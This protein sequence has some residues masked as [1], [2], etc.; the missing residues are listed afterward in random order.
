MT[1]GKAA[2]LKNQEE[3]ISSV[4]EASKDVNYE[5]LYCF[6]NHDHYCFNRTD[7]YEKLSPDFLKEY[8]KEIS[9]STVNSRNSTLGGNC[10]PSKLYY[11]WSP[12]K[13]WRFISLDCYDISLIGASSESNKKIAEELISSNNPN[14]LTI[15]S[16]WFNGLSYEKRRWVPYNGG[17]STEQIKWLK[18]VLKKSYDLNEKIVIFCHQPVHAPNKPQSLIWNS[19]EILEIIREYGNVVLWIA[20]HDHG[21]QVIECC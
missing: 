6:G 8:Q 16:G 4:L 9:E 14:D 13:N 5:M 15:G 17:V 1:L 18:E 20:G 12:Y 19:E 21:G 11:D 7:L 3:C 10:S 2:M